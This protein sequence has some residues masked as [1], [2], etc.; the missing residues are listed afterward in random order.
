[1]R[2]FAVS[3]FARLTLILALIASLVFVTEARS[4]GLPVEMKQG[5]DCAARQCARGCCANVVCCATEEQKQSPQT[6]Q[7][8][9]Q[10]DLQLLAIELRA[11]TVLLAPPAPRHPLVIRDEIQKAHTLPPLA[12]TC[13]QLI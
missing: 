11:Y 6:P 7:Q 5:G 13:I 4:V 8:H 12:A 10:Q 9:L 3:M 1:M 2:L